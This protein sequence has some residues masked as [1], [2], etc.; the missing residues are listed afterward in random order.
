MAED[1]VKKRESFNNN[2]QYLLDSI[3]Y[4]RL[5]RLNSTEGVGILKDGRPVIVKIQVTPLS[6]VDWKRRTDNG[7]K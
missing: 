2:L 5:D 3:D 4:D 7:Q 6:E 1:Q